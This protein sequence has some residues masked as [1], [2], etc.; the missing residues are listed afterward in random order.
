MKTGRSLSAMPGIRHAFFTRQ[1]GVS[2][3]VLS[4][5]NCG[6]G[7]GDDAGNVTENRQRA[8]TCLGHDAKDLNTLYQVHSPDAVVAESNWTL[9]NRPRAD[10]LAT[11]EKGLVIG[12]L[13]ADCTPVL[14]ADGENG[15]VGAAHAG[16]KGALG[17][18]LENCVGKMEELGARRKHMSAVIG[19]CIHQPSYEVGPE[20][21][22]SFIDR[23]QE[24][25]E[26]F[27]PSE[28]QGHYRFDLPGFVRR[29][30]DA[31]GLGGVEDV[32]T[33]TYAEEDDFFSYRRAT[34]LKETDYGR[35]LSAIVLNG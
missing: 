6:Y 23:N 15:V 18:V 14:F 3:G 21:F 9:D 28:R 32:A 12:I 16:W 24:F 27:V 35:G 25:S 13:T 5:L 33:D 7:S 29:S 19:P 31:I 26:H 10:A 4:S 8:M 17:G 30:L 11:R 20:F 2:T 22:Q 34:H 1:G